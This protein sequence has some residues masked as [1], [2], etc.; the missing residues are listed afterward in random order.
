V[1]TQPERFFGRV[2]ADQPWS[3]VLFGVIASTVGNAAAALYAYF[4]GQQAMLALQQMAEKLPEQEGRFVKLYAEALTGSAVLAQVILSP[5]LTFIAIYLGAA[6]IH[7]LL[8]LFRGAGR[9][10]DATLTAVAYAQG[11]MLLLAVPGCGGLLAGVWSLVSLVIGLGAIQRCGS[12]KAAAA[13]LA[14]VALVCVCACGALGLTVP[15]LLKGAAEA[16]K[17]VP[18]T[19]L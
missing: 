9:G 2:R 4:S 6:L 11:L 12:G 14:P 1:A 10:F 16:S 18:T 15:A 3:A 7:L 8:R 17:A 5:L 13:I 19:Q